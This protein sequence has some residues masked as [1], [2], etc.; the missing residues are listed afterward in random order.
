M[1]ALDLVAPDYREA[2]AVVP[3]FDYDAQPVAEIRAALLQVY[4]QTYGSPDTVAKEEVSIARE[5]E[6]PVRA[7][8]YRPK[9]GIAGGAILHIHGGGWIA[10]TAD[11]LAGFCSGIAD[12]HGVIVLSVDYRLVPEA[13]G[14]AATED[15]FTALSWLHAQSERLGVDP[16]RIAVM[17]DSAGGNLAAGVA[18][19]ARDAGLPL[20]AQ[21]LMYPALDDRTAGPDAPVSNAFAG[22]FVL[23]PKYLRQL[24]Q[25]R[26]A[27]AAPEHLRYMAPARADDLAGVAGAFIAVGGIDVLVDEALDYAGRLGRAGVPVELH[28]YPGVYHAFDLLPGGATDRLRSDL[29]NAIETMVMQGADS[30]RAR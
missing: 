12:R 16:G 27:E 28:V 30:V 21:L 19:R 13:P 3:L 5:G 24:W 1:N 10:G 20:K 29:A 22:A 11:V 7:L 9:T 26:L 4:E 23:S 25:A 15:C 17:G 18:V 14:H 8:L 2:A 6:P